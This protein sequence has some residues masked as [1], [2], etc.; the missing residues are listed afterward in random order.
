MRKIL[1]A[2][3][4]ALAAAA[5][6][7]TPAYAAPFVHEGGQIRY[8]INQLDRQIDRAQ[9]RH[10]LS[11]REANR[12]ERQVS[13]L[14]GLHANYQRGGLT[15]GEVRALNQRIDTV[16]KNIQRE[17]ADGNRYHR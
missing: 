15:R 9:A 10:L 5:V 4:L 3:P 7:A 8:Q 12:L 14:R 13:E 11:P 6:L 2:G 1:F 16:Q 17:I